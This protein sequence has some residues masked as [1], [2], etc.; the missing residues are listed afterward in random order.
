MRR[1]IPLLCGLLF[2]GAQPCLAQNCPL[3]A[4]APRSSD[5]IAEWYDRYVK[6]FRA[7]AG[8]AE[9]PPPT[10]EQ[11]VALIDKLHGYHLSAVRESLF[12]E[13]FV[14]QIQA[15]YANSSSFKGLNVATARKIYRRGSGADLD[16]SLMCIDTRTVQRP[17]DAF[18]ITIYA[19]TEMD[20]DHAGLSGLVFSDTLVNGA[21]DGKCRPDLL[22]FR[23]IVV[24]VNGGT[25]VVTYLCRKGDGGC[26]RP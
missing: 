3:P 1:A 22:Y 8:E 13:A 6:P 15:Y 7:A 24:P 11:A 9:G 5:Q 19:M 26:L 25:N 4:Y 16:F 10:L 12:F 23:R 18:G 20:C 2:G 21:I 17:D 14:Q